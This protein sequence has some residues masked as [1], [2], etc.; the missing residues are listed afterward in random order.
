MILYN[1]IGGVLCGLINYF[2][3]VKKNN[4][5]FVYSYKFFFVLWVVDGGRIDIEGMYIS[6]LFK[7]V[8]LMSGVGMSFIENGKMYGFDEIGCF[9]IDYIV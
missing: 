5:F 8:L 1:I 9:L 7:G 6:L 2:F 3:G 4:L